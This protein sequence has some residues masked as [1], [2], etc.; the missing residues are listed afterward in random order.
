MQRLAVADI[1]RGT[2]TSA[3]TVTSRGRKLRCARSRWQRVARRFFRTAEGYT[4]KPCLRRLSRQGPKAPPSTTAVQLHVQLVMIGMAL[5][6]TF[7]GGFLRLVRGRPLA[8]P[9]GAVTAQVAGDGDNMEKRLFWT[10]LVLEEP[11]PRVSGCCATAWV[12]WQRR[13]QSAEGFPHVKDAFWTTSQTGG[14]EAL[15]ARQT[16]DSMCR[17]HVILS[18]ESL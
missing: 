15:A 7:S 2:R 12:L 13:S 6:F 14:V 3:A 4:R 17:A 11:R 16:L 18:Q 9:G 1:P 10:A 5:C 8:W